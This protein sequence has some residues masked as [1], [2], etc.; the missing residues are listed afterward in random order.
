MNPNIQP[1]FKF[2][3]S[4]FLKFF[5]PMIAIT[6]QIINNQNHPILSLLDPI[7]PTTSELIS[8][9]F[10]LSE[11][12]KTKNIVLLVIETKLHR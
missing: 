10:H 5:L 2:E 7:I 1:F 9:T 3:K 6:E 8:Y 4:A 11:N 12:F